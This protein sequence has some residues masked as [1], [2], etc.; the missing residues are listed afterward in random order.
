MYRDFS[1][2]V[3]AFGSG[4]DAVA[5]Q[6]AFAL[7]DALNGLDDGIYRSV[8]RGAVFKL[9]PSLISPTV[10][11]GRAWLPA[12]NCRKSSSQRPEEACR[13]SS[14]IAERSSS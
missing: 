9:F 13:E 10:A 14:T 12:T 11:V 3:L 6:G 5:L 4:V 8:A 7:G 1:Q 2:G